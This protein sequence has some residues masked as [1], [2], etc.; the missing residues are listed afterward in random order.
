MGWGGKASK[1]AK[2]FAKLQR[3]VYFLGEK[4]FTEIRYNGWISPYSIYGEKQLYTFDESHRI[5]YVDKR[6]TNI[7][8]DAIED[9]V[10]IFDQA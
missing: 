6:D 9:G 7:L 4:G 3:D 2:V 10:K 1:K 8:L 5:K